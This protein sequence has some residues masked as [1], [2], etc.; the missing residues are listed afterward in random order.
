M[1]FKTEAKRVRAGQ[2]LT[3]Y[4]TQAT[5]AINQLKSIKVQIVALKASVAADPDY[6]AADTA[7]IQATIDTLL[8]AIAGI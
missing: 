5:N 8:A 1:S 4:E 3:D 7:A 6:T 2:S